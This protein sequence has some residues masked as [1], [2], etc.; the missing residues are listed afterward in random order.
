MVIVAGPKLKLSIL[1]VAP[2]AGISLDAKA[3]LGLAP[4]AN[5]N[6][7]A[8]IAADPII[9]LFLFIFFLL[10]DFS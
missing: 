3:G 2:L 7:V 9:H 10:L 8:R 4:A 6:A 1:I 5:A